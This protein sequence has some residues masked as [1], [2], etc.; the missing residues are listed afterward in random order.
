MNT[1]LM[2]HNQLM[3]IIDQERESQL[4]EMFSRGAT[5]SNSKPNNVMKQEGFASPQYVKVEQ[6][7]GPPPPYSVA[8]ESSMQTKQQQHPETKNKDKLLEDLQ[9]T[10]V[11]IAQQPPLIMELIMG[12]KLAIKLCKRR[13]QKRL[14]RLEEVH[15]AWARLGLDTRTGNQ[16][17]PPHFWNPPLYDAA[18]MNRRLAE[19]F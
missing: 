12:H 15:D 5:S 13:E 7:D 19:F 11:V 10:S 9:Q 17:L 2:H 4:N 16:P 6:F 8:T 1:T 14:E 18:E 3:A